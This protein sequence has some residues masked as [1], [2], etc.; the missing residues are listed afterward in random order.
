[1][2]QYVAVVHRSLS[3]VQDNIKRTLQLGRCEDVIW[4]DSGVSGSLSI[5]LSMSLLICSPVYV[6]VCK[7]Y[8]FADLFVSL[9]LRLFIHL[10][11]EDLPIYRGTY[12]Q[13]TDPTSMVL[14]HSVLY[15]FYP[16]LSMESM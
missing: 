6:T 13:S 14:I 12:L 11:T 4:N 2:L 10:S 1:M 3:G 9:S 7:V 15:Q 5:H 16:Y 8:P